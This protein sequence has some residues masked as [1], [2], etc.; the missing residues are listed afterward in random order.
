MA[1]NDRHPRRSYQEPSGPDHFI[2]FIA[3]GSAISVVAS[4]LFSVFL[5]IINLVTDLAVIERSMPY[6]LLGTTVCSVFI[7]SAY[8]GRQAQSRGMLIGVGV[9]MAY[10]LVTAIFAMQISAETLDITAFVQK[11]A[12][13]TAIG[14]IGGIVGT[15]LSDN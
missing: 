6:I 7:G 15:N 1:R 8:A 10:V 12:V 4:L 11:T 3:K 13:I 2:L 14:A 5:T 9:A